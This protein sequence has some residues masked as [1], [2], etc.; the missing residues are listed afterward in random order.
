M[1]DIGG[2]GQAGGAGGV[3]QQ[4]AGSARVTSR[5]SAI[6]PAARRKSPPPHP[7][8]IA[9]C[10]QTMA[11]GSTSVQRGVSSCADDD[12]PG[13]GH[14]QAMGQRRARQIGVD[15]RHHAADAGDAQPDR[16]IFGAIGHQQR[17][18]VALG[19]A[20]RQRP[21]GIAV[22]AA[23]P[24][25]AWLKFSRGPI[26]AGAS[27][28]RAPSSSTT[29]GKMRRGVTSIFA[30]ISSAR[31]H[32]LEAERSLGDGEGRAAIMLSQNGT[33]AAKKIAQ[34]VLPAALTRACSAA[35]RSR[36][37]LIPDVLDLRP[38]QTGLAYA[39]RNHRHSFRLRRRSRHQGG[40]GADLPDG[41]LCLRQ[42]RSRRGLFNLEEEG[43]R[44]SR[45]ANPTVAVLE[46]RV[47]PSWKAASAALATASG[48]AALHYAF[49]NVA[50]GGGNIVS[51]PQLYGTTHT[52]L[53]HRAAAVR[54]SRRAS[55]PTTAPRRWRR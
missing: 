4:S 51:P 13:A 49:A 44:Y 50:D 24:V 28:K 16:Q 47:S 36:V 29:R 17:D 18:H 35:S 14:V 38:L 20:L 31:S 53:A 19:E 8:K 55:P 5:S 34:P 6:A 26:R 46:D 25:R 7:R 27:P 54:A 10:R 41:G 40:G 12:V 2:L 15:Q 23:P 1:A 37:S 42:R 43:Y 32:A 48:Q 45:I 52:L 9:S 3:D 39:R 21:A 30:V 22:G 11:A 33:V